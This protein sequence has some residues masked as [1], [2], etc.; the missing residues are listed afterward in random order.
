MKTK[1]QSQL[2]FVLRQHKLLVQASICLIASL[3]ILLLVIVPFFERGWQAQSELEKK[4]VS[5]LELEE[6][7]VFLT[8]LDKSVLNRR[9]EVLDTVLPSSKDVLL[10]LGT[11]DGLSREL[12]LSLRGI[13]LSPGQISGEKVSQA[14]KPGLVTLDTQLT[15]SGTQENLYAFLRGIE[16][17]A[18]LM[19]VRDVKVNRL[20]EDSYNLSVMLSM[21][22][23]EPSTATNLK[24]K[25]M[26]FTDKEES[27]LQEIAQFKYYQANIE[28][29]E[30]LPIGKT[31][32]FSG[33]D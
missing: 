18:P 13:E 11:I 7:V 9:M 8:N 32:L 24:G 29:T 6:Q 20:G 28:L 17:T 33:S 25:M 23:A 31:D 27:L 16:Q 19:K 1:K 22:Y 21:M 4:R 26:L 15:I 3:A 10:Y 12:S 5:V 14:S 2:E 30:R